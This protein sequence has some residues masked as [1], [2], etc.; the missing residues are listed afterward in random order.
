[1]CLSILFPVLRVGDWQHVLMRSGL[2]AL[3]SV[4][5]R[6]LLV[7]VEAEP[8]ETP[9]R[10]PAGESLAVA[11]PRTVSEIRSIVA[12][13]RDRA[14]RRDPVR[15]IPQG[16]NTGLVGASTP[17]PD[18]PPVLIVSTA[19][20][21]PEILIDVDSAT[22]LVSGA[23][24]L[25]QLNEA[26]AVHGLELPIDVASDPYISAMVATNTGGARAMRN[27]TMANWV[28]GVEA[29]IADRACSVIGS[30]RPLRKNAT[31]PQAHQW[32]IGSSGAFGIITRCALELNP[33]PRS[34]ATVLIGPIEDRVAIELLQHLRLSMGSALA[35]FEVMSPAAVSA[36][37]AQMAEVL[38][39]DPGSGNEV[40][41]LV[42]ASADADPTDLL[43]ASVAEF[44]G[45]GLDLTERTLLAPPARIWA[46][47]HTITAG[48]RSRGS[49]LG[50][51]LS[52]SPAQLVALRHALRDL[53]AERWP[54]AEFA[55]FGHW[56]DGGT[57]ANVV[58]PAEMSGDPAAEIRSAVFGL[59]IDRF[60]GSFSAE[61]GIGP[62]NAEWWRA[63]TS[64]AEV[65]VLTATKDAVD[66]LRILGHPGIPFA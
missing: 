33:V 17:S 49:V 66:P 45:T 12:W 48:L 5:S 55:D 9:W 21:H 61:H 10:G 34:S 40:T 56:G 27:G 44:S 59:V 25:S 62:I 63:T 18:G 4:V 13:A 15:L 11:Q 8:F 16:S 22:A 2:E 19:F 36:G 47:R 28:H 41:I 58:L 23:T 46:L 6:P 57:H 20:M 30:C 29:V 51:D 3:E 64:A 43:V 52:V 1:M 14:T 54:D 39:V 37:L 32:M 26:V 7:G 24:T 53:L 31:G 50:F 42:E 65:A 35:A 38:Q 60:N